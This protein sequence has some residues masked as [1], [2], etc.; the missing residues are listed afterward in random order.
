MPQTGTTSAR[1]HRGQQ[2]DESNA[3]R[4]SEQLI[5]AYGEK[6]VEAELLR[7]GWITSNFN[8]SVKNSKD[9]DIAAFKGHS[10]VHLRVKACR[11]AAGSFAFN[12]PK[13]KE[14]E[15]KSLA[16]NDFAVLVATGREREDDVFYVLPTRAV[17]SALRAYRRDYLE[18]PK[19][20]G[21]ARNDMGRWDLRLR[22]Q[23]TNKLGSG[24]EKTW[25]RYRENW[26]ILEGI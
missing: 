25:N 1:T 14:F 10:I 5:G 20:D 7:R 6:T 21:T 22:K 17:R 12:W 4:L 2:R 9:F 8:A 11:P 26:K 3:A 18:K 19:R 24:F 13:G 16:K 23:N 15:T